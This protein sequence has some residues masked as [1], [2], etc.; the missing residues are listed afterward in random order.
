MGFIGI[1]LA[2]DVEASFGD[3]INKY[4]YSIDVQDKY[5]IFCGT[6]ENFLY[7]LGDTNYVFLG[8][9]YDNGATINYY[10]TPEEEY[11]SEKNQ[12]YLNGYDEP[13]LTDEEIAV[14]LLLSLGY[15]LTQ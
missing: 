13:E 2:E 3:P 4:K 14:Q 12:A 15:N 5:G 7:H 9:A 8:S 10:K 1:L 11:I 6:D